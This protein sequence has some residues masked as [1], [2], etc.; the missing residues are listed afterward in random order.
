MSLDS[1]VQA[2][3]GFAFRHDYRTMSG[4]ADGGATYPNASASS[5]GTTT[6]LPSQA[7]AT[8]AWVVATA[9]KAWL[10]TQ[11][12]L[13][14]V[15]AT[16]LTGSSPYPAGPT[17]I[18]FAGASLQR[19]AGTSLNPQS[20]S[21]LLI[22]ADSVRG[23]DNASL[24]SSELASL[25]TILG[26]GVF[27]VG[28]TGDNAIKVVSSGTGGSGGGT[29]TTYLHA[30]INILLIR[31]NGTNVRIDSFDMAQSTLT[32]VGAT[33]AA[34]IQNYLDGESG[35]QKFRGRV[36]YDAFFT[37]AISDDD[38]TAIKAAAASEFGVVAKSKFVAFLGD[39]EFQ[40]FY[41]LP[42]STIPHRVAMANPTWFVYN[43]ANSAA[44]TPKNAVSGS[45]NNIEED[46]VPRA[47]TALTACKPTGA[48][49]LAVV[50]GGKNDGVAIAAS[51]YTSTDVTDAQARIWAALKA[52][53][54]NQVVQVIP[55]PVA[56]VG[57]NDVTVAA[58]ETALRA[59]RT[60]NLAS[61]AIDGRVD[62]RTLANLDTGNGSA[63]SVRSVFTSKSSQWAP[64]AD[65]D[66]PTT[67]LVSASAANSC[68]GLHEGIGGQT[69]NAGFISIRSRQAFAQLAGGPMSLATELVLDLV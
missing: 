8:N 47:T 37:G 67:D 27:K 54:F 6:S 45:T 22:L 42:G 24:G 17:T 39:S 55:G 61:T 21:A 26:S 34:A 16:N 52:G 69:E 49:W 18:T 53:G 2:T 58:Y 9:N 10:V 30:G 33:G 7:G 59:I 68:D 48:Q 5:T 57:A 64:D 31:S 29:S 40:G 3:T 43:A 1:I 46:Q 4:D 35:G 38:W 51:A 36:Y 50:G 14:G 60:S 20:F 63:A 19:T 23:Q 62:V 28:K 66:S 15:S 44:K 65:T 11:N 56:Q 25:F 32:A 13:Q 12:S 41:D